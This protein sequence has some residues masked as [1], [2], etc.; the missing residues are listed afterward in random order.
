M[1]NAHAAHATPYTSHCTFAPYF[2]IG[3]PPQTA[4]YASV[5]VLSLPSTAAMP[6]LK[7]ILTGP[8]AAFCTH[9]DVHSVIAQ[10][11][12]TLRITDALNQYIKSKVSKRKTTEEIVEKLERLERVYVYVPDVHMAFHIARSEAELPPSRVLYEGAL[13]C[14]TRC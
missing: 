6:T 8:E 1:A 11:S 13:R 7:T 5:P 4:L 10:S 12:E 14:L 9:L 2:S 3:P